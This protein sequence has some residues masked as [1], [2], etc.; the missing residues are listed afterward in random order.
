MPKKITKSFTGDPNGFF[1]NFPEG[2]IFK[3]S[4]NKYFIGKKR[5]DD[6]FVD[7]KRTIRYPN[8][9][10]WVFLSGKWHFFTGQI[11]SEYLTVDGYLVSVSDDTYLSDESSNLL[12]FI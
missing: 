2:T 11:D 3:R 12:Y 5:M 4:G 1:F 9:E 10:E 6:L 8:G 7:S